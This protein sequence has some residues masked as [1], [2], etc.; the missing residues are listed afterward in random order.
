MN[1]KNFYLLQL[2]PLL[3]LLRQCDEVSD[4]EALVYGVGTVKLLAS[5][6]DLRPQ[7]VENGALSFLHS[8]LSSYLQ[9]VH[10]T[11]AFTD[12]S[13]GIVLMT[14]RNIKVKRVILSAGRS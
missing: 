9:Q 8:L 1:E 5:N 2:G 3:G 10:S 4:S 14:A 7:L 11:F 13:N 12:L 6:A